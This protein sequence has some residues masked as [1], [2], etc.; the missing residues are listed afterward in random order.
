MKF[1]SG[2][3]GIQASSIQLTTIQA[4][5]KRVEFFPVKSWISGTPTYNNS[6]YFVGLESGALPYLVTTGSSLI[7]EY[8][9][10]DTF[11]DM[12]NFFLKGTNSDGYYVISHA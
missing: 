11:Q 5:T 1:F 7:M 6:G 10:T 9:T 2:T 8:G 3:F 12:R 4:L